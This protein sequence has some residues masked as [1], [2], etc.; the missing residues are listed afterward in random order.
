VNGSSCG[1]VAPVLVRIEMLRKERTYELLITRHWPGEV[2]DGK[3]PPLETKVLFRG[4]HGRL[5][6]DL[7]GKD[8]NQ[9]GAVLPTFY[10]LAGEEST[11]PKRFHEAIRAI[12]KAVNCIGCSH[13]HFSTRSKGEKNGPK[14]AYPQPKTARE[15]CSQPRWRERSGGDMQGRLKNYALVICLF[16]F[17]FVCIGNG[18]HLTSGAAFIG[19]LSGTPLVIFAFNC[20]CDA[21]CRREEARREEPAPE[22]TPLRERP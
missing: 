3:R 15:T 21:R 6:L 14:T 22:T 7:S 12:T 8:K 11:I 20:W 5:E 13:C 9:A 19:A 10:S 16:V 4:I 1:V 2:S 17:L 18:L